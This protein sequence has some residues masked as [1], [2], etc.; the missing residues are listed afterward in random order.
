[1]KTVVCWLAL[2]VL[3]AFG[4]PGGGPIAPFALYT[5]FENQPSPPVLDSAKAE[6]TSIMSVAGLDP[7]WR[8]WETRAGE[9]SRGLA[10]INFRGRCE[11]TGLIHE[12]PD[13][14]PLGWTYVTD[15]EVLPFSDVDCD[16]VRAFLSDSLLRLHPYDR[17]HAFGRAL[18]RV[19]AHELYHVIT[20]TRH[21]GSSGVAQPAY[22]VSD[23]LAGEFSFAQADRRVLGGR[24]ASFLPHKGKKPGTALFA[25]FGCTGCHGASGQGAGAPSLRTGHFLSVSGLAARLTN[26][27]S[28]MYRQ[29]KDLGSLWPTT[30]A[31]PDIEDL[32]IYLNASMD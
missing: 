25:R 11:L 20:E 18:A 15:G 21:H 1:M 17:A 2:G 29:A 28:K 32:V 22:S 24:T 14:G 13:G 10:V 23:L 31:R 27:T 3:P 26:K 8:A 12:H 6:L 19:L 4:Q 7:E 5:R 30:L 16:R 9:V